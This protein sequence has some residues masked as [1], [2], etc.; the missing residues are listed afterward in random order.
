MRAITDAL[1]GEG[2]LGVFGDSDAFLSNFE[3][4]LS[5]NIAFFS[6]KIAQIFI[7][8]RNFGKTFLDFYI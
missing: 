8:L 6:P 1:F 5:E 3:A 2:T 4:I 7:I